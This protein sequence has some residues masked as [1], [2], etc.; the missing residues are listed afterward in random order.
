MFII[1][2]E[3]TT[4]R[5]SYCEAVQLFLGP[6]VLPVDCRRHM[7]DRVK[8]LKDCSLDGLTKKSE[9]MPKLGPQSFS[10]KN[11][12]PHW[13]TSLISPF[14]RRDTGTEGFYEEISTAIETHIAKSLDQLQKQGLQQSPLLSHPPVERNQNRKSE[15]HT[16]MRFLGPD[17]M[18][19][20]G[21]VVNYLENCSRKQ[22]RDDATDA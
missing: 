3:P 13:Q 22:G 18:G 8:E 16:D 11:R 15:G 21:C 4:R 1:T 12:T 5:G 17:L 9:F 19:R 10:E 14:C 6:M 2:S 20:L 7:K